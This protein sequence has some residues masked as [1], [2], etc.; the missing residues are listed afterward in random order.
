[1]DD[2]ELIRKR[3]LFEKSI[4][5]ESYLE[6]QRAVRRH[7]ILIGKL[8][9][10]WNAV[11]AELLLLFIQIAGEKSQGNIDPVLP[12]RIWHDTGSD[13]AQRALFL[14]FAELKLAKKPELLDLAKWA[15]V[16]LNA[17]A[18]YRNDAMHSAFEIRIKRGETNA[19]STPSVRAVQQNRLNRLNSVGHRKLFRAVIHD[20]FRIGSLI[21]EILSRLD[22]P[23]FVRDLQP[24]PDKPV[25]RARA[26]VEKSP[27][28]NDR[29][30]NP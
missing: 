25:M 22:A 26:L 28:S 13:S 30:E 14:V 10:L 8:T 17:L 21:W 29:Q 27:R 16:E 19:F 18:T 12:S 23:P 6:G 4:F 3:G 20:L 15:V 7:A 5:S 1:M 9:F 2:S 24:L 11:H